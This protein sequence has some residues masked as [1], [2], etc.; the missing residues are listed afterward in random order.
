MLPDFT[1]FEVDREIVNY[2]SNFKKIQKETN[3]AENS[4][5]VKLTCGLSI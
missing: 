2:F 5:Y 4:K 3:I 1:S